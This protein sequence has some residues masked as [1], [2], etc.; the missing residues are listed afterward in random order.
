MAAAGA[1]WVRMDCDWS[2]T[3]PARGVYNWSRLDQAVAVAS[4]YGLKTLCA[5]DFGA[6]WDGSCP[7]TCKH[8][9]VHPAYFAEFVA[10]GDGVVSVR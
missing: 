8:L 2:G 6:G 3:E 4:Q 1:K 10:G 7:D 9:P 5:L